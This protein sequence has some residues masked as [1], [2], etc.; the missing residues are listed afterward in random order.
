MLFL[1]SGLQGKDLAVVIN[2]VAE[3]DQD[4]FADLTVEKIF[5]ASHVNCHSQAVITN[6]FIRQLIARPARSAIF[7]VGSNVTESPCEPRQ[8]KVVS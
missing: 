2:N 4:E 6:S 3:S 8:V 1:R 5:R 7:S